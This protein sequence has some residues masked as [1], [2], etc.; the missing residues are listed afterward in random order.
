MSAAVFIDKAMRF[1]GLMWSDSD[2]R[3]GVDSATASELATGMIGFEI[4]AHG[5]VSV[6]SA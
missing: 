6:D 2:T 4:L 3:V 5:Q 1:S